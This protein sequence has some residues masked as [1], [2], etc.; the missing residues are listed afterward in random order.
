MN[1]KQ[2]LRN[3]LF[4]IFGP[5]ND[6]ERIEL[7]LQRLASDAEDAA[8]AKSRK[9][10]RLYQQLAELEAEIEEASEDRVRLQ[11]LANRTY[12]LANNSGEFAAVNRDW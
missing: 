7:N 1:L 11:R 5:P 9:L 3:I 12:D 10:D 6:V 2:I 4:A 8:D